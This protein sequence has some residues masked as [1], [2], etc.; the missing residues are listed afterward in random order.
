MWSFLCAPSST[1]VRVG[2]YLRSPRHPRCPRSVGRSTMGPS[3]GTRRGIGTQLKKIVL[4]PSIT[5][6]V[7]FV[8]I[9]A[10]TL[11]QAVS[12]RGAATEGEAGAELARA[13]TD[14]QN[15]RRLHAAYAADPGAD[16]EA[17]LVE[18]IEHSDASLEAVRSSRED[19]GGREAPFNGT[20]VGGFF[21]ALEGI[22]EL[23][24][25]GGSDDI[26]AVLSAYTSALREGVRLYSGITR[27]LDDG[28][29]AAEAAATTDLMWAQESFG[30]ADA[31][32]SAALAGQELTRSDQN[33]IAALTT[34]ARHRVATVH[35][36]P[37]AVD[38]PAPGDLL[39]GAPW[40]D[41]L[42]AADTLAAHEPEVT[43]EP[44]TGEQE[45]E[46]SPPETLDDWR[47]DADPVN[48]ELAA[49][50][51][52]RSEEHTSEL[53]SRGHLVC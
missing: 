41:A 19:L 51:D 29:A 40:Q 5:F 2:P 26:D 34:D 37:D 27:T 20:L 1:H 46:L 39:S 47:E 52:A 48:T 8:V 44:L 45:S 22:E 4:I 35:P 32:V 21:E 50:I 24:S 15:E 31:L 25:A 13:L 11:S 36:G 23:R 28:T 12:L 49:I 6:L 10:G 17:A 18:G 33:R 43:V 30:H 16:R 42:E 9:S 53:Q 14:L 38:G 3:G 7:L